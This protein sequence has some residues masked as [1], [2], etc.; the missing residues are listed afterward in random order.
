M[1]AELVEHDEWRYR[2]FVGLVTDLRLERRRGNAAGDATRLSA[3]LERELRLE[4]EIP[5][6]G[7]AEGTPSPDGRSAA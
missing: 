4:L 1:C 6:R 7:G 3:G 2:G 5:V